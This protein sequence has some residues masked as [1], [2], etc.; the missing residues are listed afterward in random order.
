MASPPAPPPASPPLDPRGLDLGH[1]ALF[2]GYAFADAVQA[3]LGAKGFGDLRFAHGFVFQHLV[4]GPRN[5]GELAERMEVTQQAVSKTVAELEALGYLERV[6]DPADARV[7]Q[8]Q[9]TARGHEAVGLSRRTRAALEQR[10]ARQCGAE[11][12]VAA[13]ALLADAL[14]ALGGVEA[15]RTR[16][17][18]APA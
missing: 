13:R 16:R 2:V 10:L 8:V 18:R 1:L 9:L 14:R 15:V 3:K 5:I 4:K 17:V 7:R 12:L 6:V 11:T